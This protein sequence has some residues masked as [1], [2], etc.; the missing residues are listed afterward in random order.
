M[1]SLQFSK[2]RKAP[3]THYF[4]PTALSP[5]PMAHL[6]CKDP[7]LELSP[8]A[9]VP[10]GATF[11]PEPFAERCSG[12]VRSRPCRVLVTRS[13]TSDRIFHALL[14]DV[15]VKRSLL[16][17]RVLHCCSCDG[18]HWCPGLV[19]LLYNFHMVSLQ[20]YQCFLCALCNGRLLQVPS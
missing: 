17:P 4:F 15:T 3:I 19:S 10:Q 9:P 7:P 6:S 20:S 13:S 8:R 18:H 16:S 14:T 11:C 1:K 2:L 12:F 5:G